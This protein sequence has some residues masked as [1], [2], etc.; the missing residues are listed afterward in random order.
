MNLWE[1]RF[2]KPMLLSEKNASFDDSNWL[3]EL[4]LDGQRALLFA[5]KKEVTLYN[6]YG[7]DITFL[8]PELQ[9]IRKLVKENTIFDGEIVAFEDG[10]P[11]FSTLQKRLYVKQPTKIDYYSKVYPVVY[12]AFDL[13]YQT[14]DYT[15]QPLI[16]RKE[17]LQQVSDSDV[18]AKV[19]YLETQGCS[20]FET[21]KNLK[22]EGI[23]AKRKTSF[24]FPNS[25]SEDWVKIKNWQEGIFYIG[26]Y[27]VQEHGNISLLL[28]EKKNHN[29][30]YVGKVTLP[31]HHS[32]S[33]RLKKLPLLKMSPFDEIISNACYISPTYSCTVLYLERTVK[34]H[35]RQ[36]IFREIHK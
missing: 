20:F 12:M 10:K 21:I 17:K 13:L 29:L 23:V 35:L 8:Y 5:S 2:W 1:T 14:E 7:K 30:C 24:Y 16:I 9:E 34:N 33:L 36:P 25:R 32:F 4:K 31:L 19:F 3:F 26:G 18:F 28:G 27:E 6:R 11:S 22:L 15:N